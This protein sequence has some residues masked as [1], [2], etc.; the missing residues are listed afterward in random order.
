MITVD[1]RGEHT[2]HQESSVKRQAEAA[3]AVANAGL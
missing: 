2:E 1:L 3:A